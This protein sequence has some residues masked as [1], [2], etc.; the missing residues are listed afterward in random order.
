[1]ATELTPDEHIKALQHE[2]QALMQQV[3]V[4]TDKANQALIA[5]ESNH[6]MLISMIEAA[7]PANRKAV[8]QSYLHICRQLDASP[9]NNKRTDEEI[10]FQ[11]MVRQAMF[12]HLKR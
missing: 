8:L 5:G 10:G 11:D 1:M 7:T 6:A 4:L 9:I 2:V 3:Q 12:E